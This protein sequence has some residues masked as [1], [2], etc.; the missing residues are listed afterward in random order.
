MPL[1]AE[2]KKLVEDNYRLIYKYAGTHKLDIEDGDV[3]DSLVDGLCV[4]AK[5][6][7]PENGAFSTLAMLAM[8]HSLWKKWRDD[9]AQMRANNNS[10]LS[11]DCDYDNDGDEITT[12]YDFC[13]SKEMSPADSMNGSINISNILSVLN[14]REKE[15]AKYL[16]LGYTYD[17]I[18]K[19]FGFSSR[20]RIGQI[21]AVMRKKISNSCSDS[22]NLHI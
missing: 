11:L 5:N 13:K 10:L 17:Y 3:Y 21:V 1:T 19:V 12:L 7:N 2:Q 6:Y 18:A 20:T 8:S 9:K 22:L 16:Y 4:A 14:D 15:I